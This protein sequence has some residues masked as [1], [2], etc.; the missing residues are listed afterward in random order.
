MGIMASRAPGRVSALVPWGNFFFRYRNAVF[1]LVLLAL[2]AGFRPVYPGGSERL[3][4]G[5]DLLGIGIA[6]LGQ[7][8]RAAVIGYA[9]I[10]RGGKN[11]QVYAD[12]LVTQ[13]FFG[14]S[15]NPL[16]V[17]N[18]FVLLGLFVIHGNPWVFAFGLPFF[19][20]AYCAIVAA[21]EAYLRGKFGTE[22]EEYCRRVNRW[23][24]NLRGLRRSLEGMRFAWRRVVFKEY[25]STYAWC[26]GALLLLSYDTLIYFDYNQ[27]RLYLDMLAA[28]LIAITAIWIIIRWLK[29]SRR[30]TE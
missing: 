1:P 22:Y 5:V 23:L 8:L 26:A 14:H 11:K 15:R 21:E 6:L 13:G 18:L 19:L 16:Y 17:G 20:F 25:G 10:K 4:N 7:G 3:D 12:T 24:P 2:F 29:K 9:Y 30:L 27:R 28:F